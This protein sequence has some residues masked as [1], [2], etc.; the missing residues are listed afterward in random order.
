M[1]KGLACFQRNFEKP[2]GYSESWVVR[3]KKVFL[4]ILSMTSSLGGKFSLKIDFFWKRAEKNTIFVA[5]PKT[6]TYCNN[7]HCDIQYASYWCL[8]ICKVLWLSELFW[9]IQ[10]VKVVLLTVS[11]VQYFN[12]ETKVFRKPANTDLYIHWQPFAP[13]QWKHSTFK[14]LVYCSYIVCSNEKHLYSELK[15]LPKV[16]HQNN[17]YPHWFINRVFDKVQDDFGRQKTVKSYTAVILLS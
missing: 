11:F 14:T 13:L 16:F 5:F 2:I 7:V 15:Y 10:M 1:V 17:G 4:Q 12:I 9:A 8:T 6:E 3:V